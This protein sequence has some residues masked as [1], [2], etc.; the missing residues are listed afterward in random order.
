MNAE[1]FEQVMKDA[2]RSEALPV[3]VRYRDANGKEQAVW[4]WTYIFTADGRSVQLLGFAPD[5]PQ[6]EVLLSD[7]M[8]V[9]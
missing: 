9:V 1:E 7:I 2:M 8:S 4:V 6:D 5:D 3:V